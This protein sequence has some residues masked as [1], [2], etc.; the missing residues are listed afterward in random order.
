MRTLLPILVLTVL[1]SCTSTVDPDRPTMTSPSPT[2]TAHAETTTSEEARPASPKVAIVQSRSSRRLSLV[3]SDVGLC[4]GESVPTIS[5]TVE[6]SETEIHIA[7]F[8][9]GA[10]TCEMGIGAPP[11]DIDLAA[12]LGDRAVIDVATG[13]QIEVVVVDP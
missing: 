4:P 5:T 11:H 1:S 13:Q 2:R 3:I 7:A 12:P 6:E 10:K 9:A 8:V